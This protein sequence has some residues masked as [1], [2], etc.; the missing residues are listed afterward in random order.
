MVPQQQDNPANSGSQL[1]GSLM[2]DKN[3]ATPYSDATQV[4]FIYFIF[5]IRKHVRDA[6][7]IC[8]R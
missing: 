2:I 1:F 6:E 7:N 4:N 8:L 3:S 5:N